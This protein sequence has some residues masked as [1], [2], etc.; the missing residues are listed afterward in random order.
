M[1]KVEKEQKL[2]SEQRKLA[3]EKKAKET[4]QYTYDYEGKLLAVPTKQGG[5]IKVFN[6]K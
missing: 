2:V 6:I 3:Q 4:K 5:N 1:E